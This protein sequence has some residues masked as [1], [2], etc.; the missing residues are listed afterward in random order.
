[1][2]LGRPD[3]ETYTFFV[4]VCLCLS[5]AFTVF[6]LSPSLWQPEA[7]GAHHNMNILDFSV[8]KNGIKVFGISCF[9]HNQH[10]APGFMMKIAL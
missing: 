3:S 2:C 7:G 4:R 8:S 6:Q 5:L 1:M 10:I 9:N